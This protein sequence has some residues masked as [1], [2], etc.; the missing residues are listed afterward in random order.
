VVFFERR[1][2]AGAGT[3]STPSGAQVTAGWPCER[4]GFHD[5][6]AA[7]AEVRREL[8]RADVGLVTSRC[9]DG[10][11]ATE[12]LLASRVPCRVF[13]DLDTAVTL[14]RA[15]SR[16]ASFVR[17][18]SLADFDLVLSVTGGGAL[19]ALAERC[20]ARRVAPL[21]PWGDP[22]VHRP[23]PAD[24]AYRSDLACP[25]RSGPQDATALSHLFFGA[26]LRLRGHQFLIG[27]AAA[28][29][30]RGDRRRRDERGRGRGGRAAGAGAGADRR[31]RPRTRARGAHGRL[32]RP[33]ARAAAGVRRVG[34]L[35]GGRRSARRAGARADV[36]RNAQSRIHHR[37][38]WGGSIHHGGTATRRD[39]EARSRSRGGVGAS[40]RVERDRKP[41]SREEGLG[42]VVPTCALSTTQ[43]VA[44]PTRRPSRL[45]GF[46]WLHPA[47]PARG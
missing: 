9:D 22:L 39:A 12:A 14:R 16:Q 36:T 11:A 4:R 40:A 47:T 45:P 26:A 1:S 19:T 32:P 17:S 43:A 41:G 23:V 18:I 20:G 7:L 42:V 37:E 6:D 28:A 46:L 30:G 13:Y 44:P 5:W 10:L 31:R 21:Y 34:P 38:S 25:W 15:G 35:R 2:A 24:P 29:A 3:A 8:G 33:R 27:G